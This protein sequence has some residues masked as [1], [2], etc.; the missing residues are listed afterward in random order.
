M[1][2]VPTFPVTE[3]IDRYIIAVIKN[4]KG[5]DN[6][7]ELEFYA[8][9]IKIY[10]LDTVEHLIAE[11]KN[12]HLG[13]WD[14]E[15]ELKTGTEQDL[16]LEEIGRRAIAIRDKNSQRVKIKNTIASALGCSVKEF[17]IDHLSG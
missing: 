7:N 10:N 5:G 3:L 11:L 16:P 6:Q 15:K 9:Q 12:I 13:I 14:L 2:I 8:H 4:E 17:K 1:T